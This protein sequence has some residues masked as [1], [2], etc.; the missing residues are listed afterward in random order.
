MKLAGLHWF[1]RRQRSLA[2]VA[3]ALFCLT[4]LQF[5]TAPCLM[6][7]ERG[8]ADAEH[9]G[10]MPGGMQE[11]ATEHCPYCPPAPAGA[12]ACD[13]SSC[14]FPHDPQV[15]SRIGFIAALL[16]PPTPIAMLVPHVADTTHS[17][18]AAAPPPLPHASLTVSFCRYLR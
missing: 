14:A 12:A 6:A 7:L 8:V 4:W 3:L 1:R 15:D 17:L 13:H 2:R 9:C 10:Q 11:S 18:I 16:A 5:A